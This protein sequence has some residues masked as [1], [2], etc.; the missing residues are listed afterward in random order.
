VC[1]CY[2]FYFTSYSV[3]TAV[4]VEIVAQDIVEMALMAMAM[5]ARE[6]VR[7][8]IEAATRAAGVDERRV[9]AALAAVRAVGFKHQRFGCRATVETSAVESTAS[10]TIDAR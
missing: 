8:M 7:A 4:A 3:E 6:L 9:I 5:I 10:I 1:C 2:L